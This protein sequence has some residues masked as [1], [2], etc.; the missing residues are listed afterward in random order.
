MSLEKTALCW[1]GALRPVDMI[2]EAMITIFSS[3]ICKFAAPQ[4]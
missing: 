1:A 4:T 3:N 2:W